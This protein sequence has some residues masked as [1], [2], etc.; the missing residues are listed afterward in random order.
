MQV[1][2]QV[3]GKPMIE[4]VVESRREIFA[5]AAETDPTVEAGLRL[6]VLAAHVPFA[7]EAGGVA[8]ALEIL[9][10]IERARRD[11]SVVVD[12]AMTERVEAG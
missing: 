7:E 4:R 6:I 8:C 11:G 2:N 12:D 3:N 1:A 9:R 10:K 5:L